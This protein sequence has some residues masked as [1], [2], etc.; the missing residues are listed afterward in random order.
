MRR[1]SRRNDCETMSLCS[2]CG[3][4]GCAYIFGKE[5][6]C[7]AAPFSKAEWPRLG[8]AMLVASQWQL[9][10]CWSSWLSWLGTVA[11]SDRIS[12][13]AILPALSAQEAHDL[14]ASELPVRPGKAL[15]QVSPE[16]W[17]RTRSL[18]ILGSAR[19]APLL[20]PP[21]MNCQVPPL[22]SL[23]PL[24]LHCVRFVALRYEG[25]GARLLSRRDTNERCEVRLRVSTIAGFPA[26][27]RGVASA[28]RG[29][30]GRLPLR[31][32]RAARRLCRRGHLLRHLRLSDHPPSRHR[33]FADRPARLP[34]FLCPAR[35]TPAAGGA[36]RHRRDA[37]R[38]RDHP[39]AG[40]AGALFQGRDVRFGLYDQPV[41][42]PPPTTPSSITG[43]CRWRSSF[44]SPGRR[45]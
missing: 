2:V 35:A 17:R 29:G 10:L 21:S 41:A 25:I 14:F 27:H 40:G 4:Q 23:P 16:D 12:L 7:R 1:R 33:D 32:H 20:A 45:C 43:R 30:R 39:L 31:P 26:R 3:Y 22:L 13:M 37:C 28:C 8:A 42:D 34:E 5:E 24:M 11:S 19:V 44:I 6:S 18:V 36:L 38:W 9:P 15:M